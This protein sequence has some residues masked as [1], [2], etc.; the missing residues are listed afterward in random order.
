M[1]FVDSSAIYAYLVR[2]D[3]HHPR[4]LE[5][6]RRLLTTDDSLLTTNYILV[7]TAALLQ[8]RLGVEAVRTLHDDLVPLFRIDWIAEDDHLRAME[9]VLTAG[10]RKLSLVDCVSFRCMRRLHIT[11]AFAF[12][13]H[14]REQ[15][16]TVVPE[17]A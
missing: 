7:E 6:F 1:I 8:R 13:D 16:F 5:A 15:G 9:A 10:R 14:F 4:A 2:D 3:E 11:T 17:P 12:D